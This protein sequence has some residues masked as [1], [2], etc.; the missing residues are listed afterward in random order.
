MPCAN[1]Y[2]Y[3]CAHL[4]MVD[5]NTAVR[6]WLAQIAPAREP[7]QLA[8]WAIIG[9]M[10]RG[11]TSSYA[12]TGKKVGRCSKS[13]RSSQAIFSIARGLRANVYVVEGNGTNRSRSSGRVSMTATNLQRHTIYPDVVSCAVEAQIFGCGESRPPFTAEWAGGT[14]LVDLTRVLA[15]I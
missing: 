4:D 11:Q 10:L 15:G 3:V 9:T 1:T 12:C 7:E 6:D 14:L 13:V 8:H 5:L 2:H